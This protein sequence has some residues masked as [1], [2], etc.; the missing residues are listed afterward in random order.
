MKSG[1]W[2]WKWSI[3]CEIKYLAEITETVIG[4]V[5]DADVARRPRA[6]TVEEDVGCLHLAV[7]EVKHHVDSGSWRKFTDVTQWQK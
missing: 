6:G 1:H 5:V 4:V 3:K 7:V 2:W